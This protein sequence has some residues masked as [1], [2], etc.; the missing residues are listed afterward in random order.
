[1]RRERELDISVQDA[2]PLDLL[3][4]YL[5]RGGGEARLFAALK[6]GL[7]RRTSACHDERTHL[8]RALAL[9]M[10]RLVLPEEVPA[11]IAHR[12]LWLAETLDCHPED[13][14][15]DNLG[16]RV[17]LSAC[18]ARV[19]AGFMPPEELRPREPAGRLVAGEVPIAG[20]QGRAGRPGSVG[21][22][23]LL[24]TNV[25]VR[26]EG[27]GF[28][29]GIPWSDVDLEWSRRGWLRLRRRGR[30]RGAFFAERP[31]DGLA[32]HLILQLRE[33]PLLM[34]LPRDGERLH[35]SEERL[36]FSFCPRCRR[37]IPARQMGRFPGADGSF[38][39]R[40]C[41]LGY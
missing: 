11:T 4:V 23:R 12:F 14:R 32:A 7:S 9:A 35:G 38:I 13:L 40:P 21:P 31:V 33:N 1:V 39:C 34:E 10:D 20:V 8:G 28:S 37:S 15:R 16:S 5:E 17:A 29:A 2:L 36:D 24:M 18:L 30:E 22:G 26:L 27:R 6:N 41:A 19:R 25:R 3:A